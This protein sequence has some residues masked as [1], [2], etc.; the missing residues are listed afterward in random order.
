MPAARK[1]AATEEEAQGLKIIRLRRI[2][3][4]ILEVPVIGVTP[5]IPHRWSQKALNM[6][7]AKQM[8]ETGALGKRREPKN[9]EEE[10]E[11]SCYWVDVLEDGRMVRHA[12]LPAVAFK[13][14]MVGAVRLYE[15]LTMT[16][17]KLLFYVEGTGGEQLVPLDG[18]WEMREDTPRN[19]GGVA[20]LRYR[21]QI[22]P[23][24]AT[25]KVHYIPSV[26]NPDSVIALVDA[27]G[28]LGVGDWR[29]S[30]PKSASGTY[31]QFRVVTE[32][33]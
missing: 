18:P 13:A 12:A 24:S 16:A 10:A 21:M 30:S 6:M 29:P 19:S 7:R 27:A 25:L 33:A 1:A 17:A 31:G 22:W 14:A 4:T 23:W 28:R 11:Q 15:G 5:A 9:P 2:E 20:D 32:E 8:A 26:I 3:E